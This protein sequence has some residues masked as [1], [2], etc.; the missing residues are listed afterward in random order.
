VDAGADFI[1]TQLFYDIDSFLRWVKKVREKGWHLSLYASLRNVYTF[2]PGI[3]VPIIPGIMPIQT[4]DSFMR[5]VKLCG[6]KVPPEVMS[7]LEPIH[8]RWFYNR[9]KVVSC[10]AFISRPMINK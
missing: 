8:V 6:S 7:A 9:F 1:V 3:K 5:L 4:Y 10:N 2:S